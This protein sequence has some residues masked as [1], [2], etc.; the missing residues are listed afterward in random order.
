MKTAIYNLTARLLKA[1]FSKLTYEVL[2]SENSSILNF[3]DTS[4]EFSDINS[5]FW[6]YNYI[7]PLKNAILLT[8]MKSSLLCQMKTFYLKKPQRLGLSQQELFQPIK[9]SFRL[10]R[11]RNR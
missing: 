3:D 8:A 11:S 6:A 9:L 10:Y 4:L 1:E 5:D 2:E 7:M